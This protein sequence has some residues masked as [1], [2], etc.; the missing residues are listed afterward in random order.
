MEVVLGRAQTRQR[1]LERGH[2]RKRGDQEG[3]VAGAG[4]APSWLSQAARK[5]GQQL[6]GGASEAIAA[7]ESVD[8]SE[9]SAVGG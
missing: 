7:T 6:T 9:S 5:A 2:D 4:E 1:Q 8:A 3:N